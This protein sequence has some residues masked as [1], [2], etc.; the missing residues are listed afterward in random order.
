MKISNFIAVGE[1]I[2]C[3][4]IYRTDGKFVKTDGNG[5][6]TIEYTADDAVRQLPIPAVF[7]ESAD[8]QAGKVKHCAVA[9]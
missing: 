6:P 5:K 4:R 7:T 2:H 9:V 3:T 8:W 1:N